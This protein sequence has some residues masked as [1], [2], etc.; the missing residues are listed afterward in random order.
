[1]TTF[2]KVSELM[3]KARKGKL[4]KEEVTAEATLRDDLKFDS[5]GMT[6]LL[7][8]AEDYFKLQFSIKEAVSVKTVAEMVTLIDARLAAA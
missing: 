8:L 2:E 6:E 1:M 7:V 5:L 3:V 4:N